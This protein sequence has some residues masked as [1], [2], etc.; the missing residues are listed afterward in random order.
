MSVTKRSPRPPDDHEILAFLDFWRQLLPEERAKLVKASFPEWK[1]PHIAE[2]AG[3][4]ER[5]LYR[6]PGYR[7]LKELYA[8]RKPAASQWR[9]RRR[10]KIEPN[11]ERGF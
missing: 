3:V 5:T 8:A 4:S 10:R 2:V 7:E 1:E 11:R 9:G 6:M